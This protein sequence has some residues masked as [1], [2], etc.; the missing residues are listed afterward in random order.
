MNDSLDLIIAQ[1][2]RIVSASLDQA[3]SSPNPTLMRRTGDEWAALIRML[4]EQRT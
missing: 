4:V 2:C 3:A 1:V